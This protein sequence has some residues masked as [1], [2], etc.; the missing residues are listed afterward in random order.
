MEVWLATENSHKLRETRAVLSDYSIKVWHLRRSKHEIQSPYLEKI[1][2]FAAKEAAREERRPVIVEDSGFFVRTLKGFPGPYSSYVY[3]TLGTEG[4]LRLLTGDRDREAFFQSAVAICM[5][6]TLNATFSGR[7]HGTIPRR[8]AGKHGFGF[9]PIF[10]P[11]RENRTF[12]EMDLSE[13]SRY[14]HRA[15]A[16]RKFAAWFLSEAGRGAWFANGAL[17]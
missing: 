11:H 4:I 5:Q 17:K 7:V 2:S 13:K 3:M 6:T 1:A 15:I 12:A 16:L 14:S 10:I 9:D 8:P